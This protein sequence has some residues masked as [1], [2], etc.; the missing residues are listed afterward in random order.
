MFPAN[1]TLQVLIAVEDQAT[2]LE[3]AQWFEMRGHRAR[4][5]SSADE[6]LA[7]CERGTCDVVVCDFGSPETQLDFLRA[8]QRVDRPIPVI[9]V[10]RQKDQSGRAGGRESL[11]FLRNGATDFIAAPYPFAELELRCRMA[12]HVG[13]LRIENQQLRAE[14][15][16][17][18]PRLESVEPQRAT[19]IDTASLAA[20]ERQHILD[21]LKSQRGNKARTAVLLGIH[22]RKLYRL[23]D[24]LQISLADR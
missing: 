15:Q 4:S 12:C 16:P 11:E 5:A 21:V 6:A 2:R 8:A 9:V 23:L 1:D 19:A 3:A 22:R 18:A 13:R 24:R 7:Y 17:V 14:R 20:V 10:V